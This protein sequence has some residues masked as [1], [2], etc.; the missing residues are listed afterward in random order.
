MKR[1]LVLI[2]LVLLMI[3]GLR[4][5]QPQRQDTQTQPVVV[6]NVRWESDS[7]FR[8]H[9]ELCDSAVVKQIETHA[10]LKRLMAEKTH[11]EKNCIVLNSSPA[12]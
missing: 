10:T 11:S 7:R 5:L 6:E 4:W 2:A 12:N 8:E 1:H 9:S 3:A